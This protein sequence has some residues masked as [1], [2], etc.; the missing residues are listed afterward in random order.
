MAEN[1]LDPTG[2]L[3]AEDVEFD[4]AAPELE[5]FSLNMDNG[6]VTLSFDEPVLPNS[7]DFT[8]LTFQDS[9]SGSVSYQLTGGQV[10][11]RTANTQINFTLLDTDLNAIKSLDGLATSVDDTYLTATSSLI[12]DVRSI[13]NAPTTIPVGAYTLD[14]TDVSLEAFRVLDLGDGTIQLDFSEP[15][16]I[17]SVNFTQYT[18]QSMANG[19]VTIPLTTGTAVYGG[20][21]STII[22]SLS[23]EDI[24]QLKRD[25]TIGTSMSNSF[26]SVSS[27]GIT[28]VAGNNLEAVPITDALQLS[29]D[30]REDFVRASLDSF[31]LDM[32]S[33]FVMLTFDDVIDITTFSGS[34]ITLQ[35]DME[36]LESDNQYIL[37]GVVLNSTLPDYT[38]TFQ[39]TATDLHGLQ[40]N[41]DLATSRNNTYISIAAT[42]ASAVGGFPILPKTSTAALQVTNFAEDETSPELLRFTLDVNEGLLSLV[43]SEVVNVS[44]FDSAGLLIQSSF[45]STASSVQLG[46]AVPTSTEPDSRFDVELSTEELELVKQ[47]MALA[48]DESTT[49]LSASNTTVT[50]MVGLELVAITPNNSLMAFD[51]VA[52]RTAPMLTN[53]SID[54]NNGLLTLTFDE[55]VRLT[56]FNPRALTFQSA[57]NS[58]STTTTIT[59]TAGSN[60]VIGSSDGTEFE[61]I[62]SPFDYNQINADETIAR[63]EENT[64]L[65]LA[66]GAIEDTNNIPSAPILPDN[67]LQVGAFFLD[68]TRPTLVSFDLDMDSGI[69]TLRFSEPVDPLSYTSNSFTLHN[70]QSSSP[71]FSYTLVEDGTTQTTVES[72]T[73][74]VQL[75]ESDV[76]QIKLAELATSPNDTYVSVRDGGVADVF[77]NDLVAI[78]PEDALGVNQFVGDMTPPAIEFVTVDLENG[79]LRLN[80]SEPIDVLSFN[81]TQI[82]ITNDIS[83]PT[84]FLMLT[85]GTLEVTDATT[86]VILLNDEDVTA[87][88][89]MSTLANDIQD[90]YIALSAFTFSDRAGVRLTEIPVDAARQVD[91]VIP[92]TSA[93]T[94]EAFSYEAPGDR[95]GVV[96]VLR[97]SEVVNASTFD[98]TT[99]TLQDA[100]NSADA[101]ESYSL[102]DALYF[103]Q[104][105]TIL[106]VNITGDDY[107]EILRREPLGQSQ[108]TTYLSIDDGA[109]Q[110]VVQMDLVGIPPS[111][112]IRAAVYTVDLEPPEVTAFTFNLNR[113]MVIL[114]FTESVP[115]TSFNASG[116][117][118]QNHQNI[119]EASSVYTL[120]GGTAVSSG[121]TVTISLSMTD[122]D[123]LNRDSSIAVSSNTTFIAISEYSFLDSSNNP[124]LPISSEEAIESSVFV[125]DESGPTLQSFSLVL[126]TS[127]LY[128][129]FS[130]TLNITTLNVTTITIQNAAQN[131][132]ESLSLTGG[133]FEDIHSSVV[134]VN[135]TETDF[136]TLQTLTNL[137]TLSVNT[138]ISHTDGLAEDLYGNSATGLSPDSAL[139]SAQVTNDTMRPELVAFDYDMNSGVLTLSF[140]EVVEIRSFQADQLTFQNLEAVPTNT[141]TLQNSSV[142]S[143][144]S[145]IIDIR[146]G[147]DDFNNLKAA[148]VCLVEEMCFIAYTDRLITDTFSLAV[149]PRLSNT[150]LR[151]S[152]YDPDTIRP[153]L[154]S[155]ASFDLNLAQ[156]TLVFS[157]TVNTSSLVYSGITIQSFPTDPEDTFSLTSG[158]VTSNSPTITI[159]L[160]TEDAI[161]LKQNPFLCGRQ[162]TCYFSIS[163]SAIKD[164]S[165]NDVEEIPDGQAPLVEDYT[166]DSTSPTL[167][168][169][170]LDVNMGILTLTFD[171]IV[172]TRELQPSSI[173][174]R[175][176]SEAN[177][178]SYRLSGGERTSDIFSNEVTIELS[179]EDL[180]GIKA[181]DFAK[182]KDSTYL[183]IESMAITDLSPAQNPANMVTIQVN[184][185]TQ[186]NEDPSLISYHLDLD[187]NVLVFTFSEPMKEDEL[188]LT[189]ISI[190]NA[191]TGGD[192]YEL[193]GGDVTS[194]N[195]RTIVTIAFSSQ[196]LI[197]FKIPGMI[198]TMATN[199]F[200]S[201]S[202]LTISDTGENPLP[203]VLRLPATDGSN[204][205]TPDTSRMG[206]SSFTLDIF[207]GRLF[208]TFDDVADVSTFVATGITLQDDRTSTNEVQLSGDSTPMSDDDGLVVIVELAASDR[209]ALTSAD[210]LATRVENTF[211]TLEETTIDGLDGQ[212]VMPILEGSALQASEVVGGGNGT[213][214]TSFNLD[215]AS[216]VLELFFN[217]QVDDGSYTA[218]FVTLQDATGASSITLTGGTASSA[219]SGLQV[220]IQ[221]TQDD[222][223]NINAEEGVGTGVFNTYIRL[224]DGA[225]I[226]TSA[227]PVTT[228]DELPVQVSEVTPDS[229]R[230]E[231]DTYYLD[232]DTG[233]IV[234]TFTET[235]IASSI[236]PTQLT[237]RDTDGLT[238]PLFAHTLT[239]GSAMENG[240]A[241]TLMLIA[242]DLNV[243]KN[244][245]LN[246]VYLTLGEEFVR[247]AFFNRLVPVDG[248]SSLF[249]LPD[250]SAPTLESFVLDLDSNSLILTFSEAVRSSGIDLSGISLQAEQN[251]NT[252]SQ[253][254]ANSEITTT[255]P[256][257][258]VRITIAGQD[259]VALTCELGLGISTETTYIA[260][261]AG[262]V[263]DLASSPTNSIA[264]IPSTDAIQAEMVTEDNTSPLLVEWSLDRNSG[265]IH[266]TF[267]ECINASAVNFDHIVIQNAFCISNLSHTEH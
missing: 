246:A 173:L 178:Q 19:G 8:A 240:P 17:A 82:R 2:P 168:S 165:G 256:S 109:I 93:P 122:L 80:V 99:I 133:S 111:N 181:T 232:L 230:P 198:A 166:G 61:V 15:V 94:L 110:D 252:L 208:L 187:S 56:T 22:I 143:E 138:F 59:L 183:T 108:N 157:E 69:L 6:L 120:S 9:P 114:T 7:R 86:A 134:I 126:D 227:G 149:L 213:Q 83:A 38:I 239:G 76:F 5:E 13:A 224:E 12:T 253:T 10:E 16:D 112:A 103:V 153:Q 241:I 58:L 101:T 130:E 79:Q 192:S 95:A 74:I 200:V 205:F 159:T 44:S 234:L 106:R 34:G 199:T 75:P 145:N 77:L 105:T 175:E 204:E 91:S 116:V 228:P 30:V 262:S 161:T 14:M 267:D 43:F 184:V 3:R 96:L 67:A 47:M 222:L 179:S 164:M 221:L 162:G 63:N 26:I 97:F 212:D 32:D 136:Y 36:G 23:S 66:E 115:S 81:T 71:E 72:D 60:V 51:H 229:T 147:L 104:P 88:K 223:N 156:F 195:Q 194:T 4:N 264:S 206:L 65:S 85:G 107:A 129:T 155:F 148:E 78:E 215:M 190:H 171:E 242:E 251:D 135:I 98:P 123:I 167:D 128:L 117:I 203:Q 247:D 1:Q 186:D 214:L 188:R 158:T 39:L 182:S 237:L 248:L 180:N 139:R 226:D 150:G 49:Y 64:Y 89:T 259:R 27:A 52:D 191:A 68:G 87:L 41:P 125:P 250:I 207:N 231:L 121:N 210:G 163:S 50:D 154:V 142:I 185:Y 233:E 54:L 193:T 127:Q 84:A 140:D 92:D 196:D 257:D 170:D 235:V 53:F 225:F 11:T 236:D 219:M 245:S 216:E 124:V 28:D 18:L 218:R 62:L 169:F 258:I 29:Q 55:T 265:S 118:I 243:L 220:N 209:F 25:D 113:A 20:D 172:D 211:I 255:Y 189:G 48:T 202:S 37:S 254:L 40:A 57:P 73:L 33:G 244:G 217:R 260:I 46:D 102:T 90:T 31:D 177:A 263:E 152:N 100:S 176:S 21:K 35:S 146:L 119:S 45:N 42:A 144:I 132:T 174:I 24:L 197:A 151:V 70:N 266:L 131:S 201:I 261:S 137:G 141:Y 160:S 249:V 238:P